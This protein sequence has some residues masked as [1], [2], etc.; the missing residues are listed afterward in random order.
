MNLWGKYNRMG[1]MMTEDDTWRWEVLKAYQSR[2]KELENP[3]A[4][5]LCRVFSPSC[6]EGEEGDVYVKDVPIDEMA[7][8]I[9]EERESLERKRD[10]VE[11]PL[12]KVEPKWQ[13]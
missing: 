7:K 9:L 3:V 6:P 4:R 12:G 13:R 2:V 5:W 10:W 11:F 1:Y 8:V